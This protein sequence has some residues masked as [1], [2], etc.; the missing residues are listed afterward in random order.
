LK[1]LGITNKIEWLAFKELIEA[2][3][4]RTPITLILVIIKK[5]NIKKHAGKI[6]S[7]R[8][9]TVFTIIKFL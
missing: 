2:P 3:C 4:K 7:K 9:I 1:P 6:K 8:K 5:C